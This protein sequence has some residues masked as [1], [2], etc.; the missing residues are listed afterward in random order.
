MASDLKAGAYVFVGPNCLVY[1]GVSIGAYTMLANDVQ[2]V[3]GDH[4]FKTPGVPM[5]FA[6]R[7]ERKNTKIGRDC[8]IGAR[9]IIMT[10]VEIGDGAIV[11]AG[12]VVTKDVEAYSIYAGV[13]ARKIKSRF[14]NEEDIERHKRFLNLSPEQLDLSMVQYAPPIF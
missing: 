13:P 2:I 4:N 3:G 6:G 14:D 11:A 8:W 1:P 12:S 9:S 7:E 10:G 5:I